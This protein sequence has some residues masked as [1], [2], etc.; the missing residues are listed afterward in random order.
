MLKYKVVILHVNCK[1]LKANV[2]MV[3]DQLEMIEEK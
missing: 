2:V 1:M 3:A